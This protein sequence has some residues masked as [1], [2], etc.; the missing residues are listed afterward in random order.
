MICKACEQDEAE[1]GW[2]QCTFCLSMG[3]ITRRGGTVNYRAKARFDPDLEA[4]AY[5]TRWNHAG[6]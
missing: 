3:A 6:W 5:G 2:Y 1:P 4:I